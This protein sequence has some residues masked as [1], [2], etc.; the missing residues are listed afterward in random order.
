MHIIFSVSSRNFFF[1]CCI[2][3]T[4]IGVVVKV[5][6]IVGKITLSLSKP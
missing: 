2:I 1:S 4:H 6:N 5:S 3:G